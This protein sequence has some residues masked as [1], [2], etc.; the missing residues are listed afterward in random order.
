VWLYEVKH[1][2]SA[3]NPKVLVSAKWIW[4]LQNCHNEYWN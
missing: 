4:E 3:C 2:I 1:C